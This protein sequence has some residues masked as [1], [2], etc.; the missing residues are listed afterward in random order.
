MATTTTLDKANF[1]AFDGLVVKTWQMVAAAK[2]ADRLLRSD[3]LPVV[4]VDSTVPGYGSV[5]FALFDGVLMMDWR[6]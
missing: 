4:A 3:S 5:K 1:F 2:D 6:D